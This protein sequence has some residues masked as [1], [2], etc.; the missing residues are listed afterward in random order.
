MSKYAKFDEWKA[1]LRQMHENS[2]EPTPGAMLMVEGVD[3]K[4]KRKLE[5]TT[6]LDQIPCNT[7]GD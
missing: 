2:N 7:E 1:L 5:E 4:L 3:E 6:Y